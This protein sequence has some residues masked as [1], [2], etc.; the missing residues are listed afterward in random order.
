MRKSIGVIILLS[1]IV[2]GIV[3]YSDY[4]EKAGLRFVKSMGS[5]I[6]IGNTLDS[7]GVRERKEDATV[8]YYETYWSNPQIT[9]K[10]ISMIKVA[11]FGTVRIPVSWDEHMDEDGNV[12]N[13]WLDRVEEVVTYAIEEGLYVIL[14]THHESWLIPLP[15]T[16]EQTKE[17]LCVLW[18][19]IAQRFIDYPDKLLYEGM[20]EPRTIVSEDEWQGGTQEEREVVNRLNAAFL[21]TVRKTGGNNSHRWLIITSYGGNHRAVT[22]K[23]L[24]IPKDEN[25]IVAVHPYIPYSFTQ[26]EDGTSKWSEQNKEDI[27]PI[28]ELIDRLYNL[29]I[30]HDIPVILTE[31]GCI[32]KANPKDRLAWTQYYTEYAKNNKIGHIWWDD[33]KAYSLMDRK[34]YRWKEPQIVKVLTELK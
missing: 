17:R 19:Q 9:K 29:Y 28:D 11:G 14:D 4:R 1:C 23:S 25:I 24:K 6:N 8:E 18:Q 7:T 13:I 10:L 16:E 20:N 31:F 26:D 3:V 32:D 2:L 30:K 27:E 22:L 34:N 21:E 33:G 15:K 5:G 12:D